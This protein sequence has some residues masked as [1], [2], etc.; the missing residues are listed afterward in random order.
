M[1]RIQHRTAHFGLPVDLGRQP[2]VFGTE[3]RRHALESTSVQSQ[4]SFA[5]PDLDPQTADQPASRGYKAVLCV[6]KTSY[7]RNYSDAP[8]A[9]ELVFTQPEPGKQRSAPGLQRILS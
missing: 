3:R 9:L 4:M 7:N 6:S 1:D 2:C 8:G 5:R